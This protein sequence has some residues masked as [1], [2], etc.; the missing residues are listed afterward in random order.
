MYGASIAEKKNVFSFIQ[1]HLTFHV[2]SNCTNLKLNIEASQTQFRPVWL[3]RSYIYY[4]TIHTSTISNS[5]ILLIYSGF[6]ESLK[7]K[8]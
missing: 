6:E 7:S 3:P 5:I 1:D 2:F 8:V 4:I